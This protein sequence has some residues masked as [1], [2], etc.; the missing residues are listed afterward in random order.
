MAISIIYIDFVTKLFQFQF[1]KDFE[2][3]FLNL[4]FNH[5]HYETSLPL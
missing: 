4:D 2:I 1:S 3:I 5:F